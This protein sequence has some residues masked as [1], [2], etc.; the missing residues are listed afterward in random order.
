[1]T[2]QGLMHRLS[3]RFQVP[4]FMGKTVFA[5]LLTLWLAYRFHLDSP[6][7]AVITVF[8]V[9][10]SRNGMVLAKGFY[11]AFGTLVGSVVALLLAAQFA[12]D[13]IW[14][15]AG[16]SLWVGFCTAGA[17]YFRNFQA[18]AFVL[19]GYTSVLVGLPA[20][21]HPGHSFDIA[22]ARVSDVMLGIGVASLVS[23]TVFPQSLQEL[24]LRSAG[25]RFQHFLATSCQVLQG[26]IPRSGWSL[27]HLRAIQEILQLDAY[28]SGGVFENRHVRLQN[29][30]I[31][32]MI[33]EMMSAAGSLHLLNSQIRRLRQE[34][35]HTVLSVLAPVLGEVASV[36]QGQGEDPLDSGVSAF[37][38]RLEALRRDLPGVLVPLR[39]SP[40]IPWTGEEVLALD[41]TLLLLSRF[42]ED[43]YW[44]ARQY[45]ALL[46]PR[47]IL[48]ATGQEQDLPAFGR[49]YHRVAAI[50]QLHPDL[51]QPL[52]AALRSMLV[53]A[54]VSF[55]WLRTDWTSGVAATIIAVVISALFSTF[56][57]PV[58]AVRQMAWGGLVAF[59]AALLFAFLVVPRVQGFMA[60]S[61]GLLPFLLLAPYLLSRPKWPGVAAGYGIFFP[62]L[63]IPGNGGPFDY[64]GMV[65]T[66]IAELVAVLVVGLTFLVILPGGNW[67]ERSR[68]FRALRMQMAAVCRA[69]LLGLRSS[70]ERDG[71]ELLRQLVTDPSGRSG[72]D[73]AV[74]RTALRMQELGEAILHLRML[75]PVWRS[76][77]PPDPGSAG[78]ERSVDRLLGELGRLYAGSGTF[79]TVRELL[80]ETVRMASDLPHSPPLASVH[81]FLAPERL[82]LVYLEV[83]RRVLGDLGKGGG[84]GRPAGLSGMR[85]PVHAP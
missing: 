13:R 62:Q 64:P 77:T 80:D 34:T 37:C 29:R 52:T 75:H 76:S 45:Q 38:T 16:L 27:L 2:A 21:L 84:L 42:L 39:E 12:Q 33:A 57:D 68:L 7:T 81:P 11:R 36:L 18:Y 71:R 47:R 24:L 70:F 23:A 83:I 5:A 9:M 30:K 15:L 55:F 59:S 53:V 25:Q 82:L 35:R 8:I 19:S 10:Q 31:H 22:I 78:V 74:L 56:P 32:H 58:L 63:A 43:L 85:R 67:L 69:P 61:L 60:L 51:V 3:T 72:A 41:A 44:Y 6:G 20:A 46:E 50:D 17:R 48:P 79:T 14:F 28:R 4:V 73:A 49:N 66:G 65:N 40:E 26:G 54:L 1:M